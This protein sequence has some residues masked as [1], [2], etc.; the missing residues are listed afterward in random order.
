[1]I[2]WGE[3][4]S[5]P[6]MKI[7]PWDLL[8][9]V[10]RGRKTHHTGRI[11]RAPCWAAAAIAPQQVCRIWAS[12]L[13]QIPL[14][15]P[16]SCPILLAAGRGCPA[17]PPAPSSCVRAARSPTP[18]AHKDCSLWQRQRAAAWGWTV[19]MCQML[20]AGAWECPWL[21]SQT[22]HRAF[23]RYCLAECQGV[24]V[25][26]FFSFF[27]FFYSFSQGCKSKLQM[28]HY[29]GPPLVSGGLCWA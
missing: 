14:L 8:S 10:C 2:L 20:W 6:Q 21:S 22:V 7:S 5:K 15:L 18:P 29:S 28:P 13:C 12:C 11:N 23:F 1:M 9:R 27:S 16:A 17:P 4:L 3:T 26:T 19:S 24:D 25:L